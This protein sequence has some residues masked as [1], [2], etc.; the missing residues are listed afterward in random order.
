MSNATW[1]WANL[2]SQQQLML[3]HAE[4]T[5]GTGY[6]V[7]FEP[8]DAGSEPSRSPPGGLRTATLTDSQL[9]CLSGLEEQL[10]AV[11]VAYRKS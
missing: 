6:L 8:G 5:L 7:A 9:E 3:S 1:N 4:Q 2:N 10:H 11:V